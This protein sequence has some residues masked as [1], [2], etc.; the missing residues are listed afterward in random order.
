MFDNIE[1]WKRFY[2]TQE[3]ARKLK[4][5]ALSHRKVL[6]R[7]I[8]FLNSDPLTKFRKWTYPNFGR[9]NCVAALQQDFHQGF[10]SFSLKIQ[11]LEC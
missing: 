8:Y 4:H 10:R 11:V 7:E 9:E 2:F 1:N 3:L 6:F 5:F